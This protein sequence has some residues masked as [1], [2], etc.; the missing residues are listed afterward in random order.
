MVARVRTRADLLPLLLIQVATHAVAR[1]T[2]TTP[3]WLTQKPRNRMNTRFVRRLAV[4]LCVVV[5]AVGPAIAQAGVPSTSDRADAKRFA[6]MYWEERGY[7]TDRWRVRAVVSRLPRNVNGGVYLGTCTIRLN[8]DTD[9]SHRGQRDTWWQVC[10]TM[11]HEYGHLPGI[12]R[13]HNNNPESIM[14]RAV[15]LNWRAAWWPYFPDCRYEG[16]DP[17]GDGWPDW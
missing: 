8:R 3:A 11:I 15:S 5:P 7:I 14:A 4:G 16:D 6:R 12:E 2:K 17:D 1:T 10:H 9:W 13:P